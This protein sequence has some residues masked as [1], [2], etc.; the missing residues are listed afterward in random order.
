MG[1]DIGIAELDKF[2]LEGGKTLGQQ[3]ITGINSSYFWQN[4]GI[5]KIQMYGEG[6]ISQ[7]FPTH[8]SIPLN[9]FY[10]NTPNSPPTDIIHRQKLSILKIL[11]KF[12]NFSQKVQN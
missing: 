10:R 11:R 2:V 8:H 3:Q 4:N 1:N 5:N 9:I 7:T 12:P 6:K